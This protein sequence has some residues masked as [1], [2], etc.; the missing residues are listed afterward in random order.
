[1]EYDY[2]TSGTSGNGG[3]PNN[4]G[5][6]R[7]QRIVAPGLGGIVEQS[8]TY[9]NWNRLN[10]FSETRAGTTV[11]SESNCYDEH[12]NRAVLQRS[13][14]TAMT[15]QVASCTAQNMAA[16]FTNNRWNAAAYEASG[17]VAGDGRSV[18]RYNAEGLAVQNWPL[19]QQYNMTTTVYDGEGRRVARTTGTTT[20]AYV[21]DAMGRLTAEYGGLAT[22]TGTKYLHA[23]ALGSTRLMTDATGAVWRRMDYWP[24]GEEIATTQTN[25]RTA[26]LGY[27]ADGE[28]RQK[29]TGK[30]RDAETGLDYFGARYFSAAQGRWTS[31]DWSEKPQPVPYADLKDPQT[32]N[33]YAYVRNGPLSRRDF[34]GHIDCSGKNAERI[35]CQLIAQWNADH[36]VR[37][38]SS[39]RST[40]IVHRDGTLEKRT[41]N[42]AYRNNNPGNMRPYTSWSG[43]IGVD[44]PV[45]KGGKKDKV[46]FIVFESSSAGEA[47]LRTL[48]L[49]PTVQARS[50]AAEME[51]FAPATDDNDPVAYAAALGKALGV[52]ASLAMSALT[53][54]QLDAFIEKVKQQEGFYDPK[55][56]SEIIK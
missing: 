28:P 8:Y 52:D 19:G 9:D 45:L 47:A 44:Q 11:L 56:K 39:G 20:T 2:Q 22:S 24:F 23:D 53:P 5:N 16:V 37:S 3:G 33:L 21:Y 10:V 40:W 15:P 43:A 50:I 34:D 6:P 46:G 31:P 41:G 27:A 51:K 49:T 55:G 12:G 17:A 14:L 4:N 13:D 30:E 29:F 25:Y 35:G 18:F 26:A 32:L 42:I 48:M 54:A 38:S 7:K 1:M 36:G